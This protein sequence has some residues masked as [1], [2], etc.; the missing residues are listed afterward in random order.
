MEYVAAIAVAVFIFAAIFALYIR[1]QEKKTS[2]RNFFGLRS[3]LRA[4]NIVFLNSYSWLP[5]NP[6]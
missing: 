1:H 4:R 6:N 3:L 5:S 2:A